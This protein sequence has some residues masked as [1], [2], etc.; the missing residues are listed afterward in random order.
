MIEW[1]VYGYDFRGMDADEIRV[2]LLMNDD[3][4]LWKL[5]EKNKLLKENSRLINANK[6][7]SITKEK[8]K[9]I[10]H[11]HALKVKNTPEQIAYYARAKAMRVQLKLKVIE[12]LTDN[13]NACNCCGEKNLSFLTVDHIN[14]DG[15][16]ERRNNILTYRL[17]K[18]IIDY[19][20]KEKYQIL[21]FNCNISK[22]HHQNVCSHSL[23]PRGLNHV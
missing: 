23:T 9:E 5:I 16:I 13:K 6:L 19:P 20:D 7:L 15:K 2:T 11:K 18:K 22:S 21:C 14:A 4:D 12:L 17:Y 8:R 1:K 3:D 10:N